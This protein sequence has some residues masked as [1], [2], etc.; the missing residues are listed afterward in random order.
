MGSIDRRHDEGQ[1]MA[2]YR[3]TPVLVIA[4]LALVAVPPVAGQSA[5]EPALFE[6]RTP[7]NILPAEQAG[8]LLMESREELERPEE[9]LDSMG[10]EDGDLVA[11]LG[12]GNGY[13][14]LRL[15]RR[16]G[17]HGVVFAVDIQEG[18]LAQLRE[19]AAEAGIR[20]VHPILGTTTDP[21]LPDAAMD[22][23]LL[24][25]VYHELSE[26][27]AMLERIRAALAPGGRV[28]LL[29]Y[30]AE[31]ESGAMPAFI[32]RSH[33]MTVHEV[34]REWIPAG[35]RLV[36]FHEFLPAQHFFVFE[37]APDAP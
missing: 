21:M 23:I 6:S 3:L 25:D 33:K 28:A 36:A 5:P 19:R 8:I 20:N 16:V 34:V 32:P 10:L 35:F 15:A 27:A 11:D 30:R 29:E 4:L 2:A 22:W 7:A 17:P 13:Y 37:A 26:P 1:R 9:I 18:M 14:S 31:Q 12:C 24:V